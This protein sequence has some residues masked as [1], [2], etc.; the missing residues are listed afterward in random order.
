LSK[1]QNQKSRFGVVTVPAFLASKKN[2]EFTMK[3]L[4]K[5]GLPSYG[6]G[7]LGT[8]SAGSKTPEGRPFSSKDG[9][10]YARG[11][12]WKRKA[13]TAYLVNK[14]RVH[15]VLLSNDF[16]Q[17]TSQ[18]YIEES[19]SK[20]SF[21]GDAEKIIVFGGKEP[22]T[23]LAGTE[24]YETLADRAMVEY[25][26]NLVLAEQTQDGGWQVLLP[27]GPG[28]YRLVTHSYASFVNFAACVDSLRF[29]NNG[30][31]AGIPVEAWLSYPVKTTPDGSKR[32]CATWEFRPV[33]AA[34]SLPLPQISGVDRRLTLPFET[35]ALPYQAKPVAAL[36]APTE[37]SRKEKIGF[38]VSLK[39]ELGEEAFEKIKG[40]CGL[41]AKTSASLSDEDVD[42][43]FIALAEEKNNF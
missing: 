10:L 34:A 20:L 36:P 41:T 30:I 37:L 28:I 1:K 25:S 5:K 3:F 27:D 18:S 35:P 4:R 24:E 38:I 26:V 2:K 15:F 31:C 16:D 21:R 17:I 9:T 43:L 22:R 32:P 14:K 6:N 42:A 12:E 23:V 8:I 11:D 40:S 33:E 7:V 19:Q 13:L 29:L 39:S